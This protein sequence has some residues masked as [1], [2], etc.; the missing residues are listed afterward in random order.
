VTNERGT[1]VGVFDSV[2]GKQTWSASEDPQ[3]G[4]TVGAAT[5]LNN[6]AGQGRYVIAE[7]GLQFDLPRSTYYVSGPAGGR[8]Q[9][10]LSGTF[11]PLTTREITSSIQMNPYIAPS[12]FQDKSAIVASSELLNQFTRASSAYFMGGLMGK[13]GSSWNVPLNT[14]EVFGQLRDSLSRP[15]L[16]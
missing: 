1:T 11:D 14:L 12:A 2:T 3:G 5:T 15:R 16:P 8:F 4:I 9:Q 10:P 7:S 6:M 13:T